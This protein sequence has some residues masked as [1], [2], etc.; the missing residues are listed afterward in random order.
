MGDVSAWGVF[1]VFLEAGDEPK[2][3]YCVIVLD[4]YDFVDIPKIALI[5]RQSFNLYGFKSLF[6]ISPKVFATNSASASTSS[7]P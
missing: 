4:W 3:L 5:E 1:L 6:G 7:F 2:R